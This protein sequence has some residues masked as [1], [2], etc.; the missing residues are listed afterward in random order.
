MCLYDFSFLI[1]R[2]FHLILPFLVERGVSIIGKSLNFV[3]QS[4]TDFK[5]VIEEQMRIHAESMSIFSNEDVRK[6]LGS[7]NGSFY[8]AGSNGG[9]LATVG[10][11]SGIGGVED[12]MS[13]QGSGCFRQGPIDLSKF[14][15]LVPL[16]KPPI[17]SSISEPLPTAAVVSGNS[18]STVFV[19]PS[20][21]A[22]SVGVTAT[23]LPSVVSI[24]S[25]SR[26]TSSASCTLHRA[27]LVSQD[28]FVRGLGLAQSHL[29]GS[30]TSQDSVRGLV[31]LQG[32]SL[33]SQESV[34]RVGVA[35]PRPTP[36]QP[37]GNLV[38]QSSIATLGFA[39]GQVAHLVS[40]DS[41][42][43]S[44]AQGGLNNHDTMP[45][46]IVQGTLIGNDAMALVATTVAPP[47][48]NI[49]NQD[50]VP[51]QPVTCTSGLVKQDSITLSICSSTHQQ[52]QDSLIRQDSIN[53]HDNIA[54]DKL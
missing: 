46:N 35:I 9:S 43:R 1:F 37:Q 11:G 10:V 51:L 52:Q 18:T 31:N 39:G 44:I 49:M 54:P 21:V 27:S 36:Q 5:E 8:L 40:Q 23:A 24:S 7:D 29:Q 47:I 3:E 19:P 17:S 38:R 50:T 48:G 15:Q 22:A 20:M 41:L 32:S 30:L 25:T 2:C 4:E 26:P 13:P 6:S 16:K 53:T 14:D 45:R 42:A 28:S 12:L 33:A 34:A